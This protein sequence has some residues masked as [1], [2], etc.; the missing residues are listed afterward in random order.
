MRCAECGGEDFAANDVDGYSTCTRCGAIAEEVAWSADPQFIKQNGQSHA[1]GNFIPAAAGSSQ[2]PSHLR[3]VTVQEDSREQASARGKSEIYKLVD[4]LGVHPRNDVGKQA[5][6]LYKLAVLQNFTRGRS[7]TSV[8]CAALY[9]VCRQDSK[10][11][12]LIDFSDAAS[13]DIFTLG[14]VFTQLCRTLHLHQHPG[15]VKPIDPSLFIHRYAEELQVGERK[16]VVANTALR[17]VA[18]MKRDWLV[19]G[20]RPNGIC[21]AALWL[22]SNIHGVR[23]KKEEVVKVVHV[24]EQTIKKRVSEFEGTPSSTLTSAEFEERAQRR[25]EELERY[26]ASLEAQH[27]QQQHDDETVPGV[28]TMLKCRH[29]WSTSAQHFAHGMCMQCFRDF[30]L[31]HRGFEDGDD[32]PAL[33]SMQTRHKANEAELERL[34]QSLEHEEDI[35]EFAYTIEKFKQQSEGSSPVSESTEQAQQQQNQKQ[36][37]QHRVRQVETPLNNLVA[38]AQRQSPMCEEEREDLAERL[39]SGEKEKLQHTRVAD[40]SDELQR[41][42]GEHSSRCLPFI[43]DKASGMAYAEHFVDDAAERIPHVSR[44]MMRYLIN[45]G[46]FDSSALHLLARYSWLDVRNMAYTTG[47]D[48]GSANGGNEE[49]KSAQAAAEDN[50]DTRTQPVAMS[51]DAVEP[52]EADE[53]D[54]NEGEDLRLADDIDDNEIDKY[55]NSKEAKEW[56][57]RVWEYMNAKWIQEQED[58]RQAREREKAVGKKRQSTKR[59]RSEVVENASS[60]QE[61]TQKVLSQQQQRGGKNKS[62]K[63]N[64]ENIQWL[65]EAPSAAKGERATSSTSSGQ[66]NSTTNVGS[67]A[68]L[69]YSVAAETHHRLGAAVTNGGD[70]SASPVGAVASNRLSGLTRRRSAAGAGASGGAMSKKLQQQQRQQQR[71]QQRRQAMP[72]PAAAAAAAA[73][74]ATGER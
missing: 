11:F 30:E 20:R 63:V 25:H 6:R 3:A 71:L 67:N 24:C 31:E 34:K 49:N 69:G 15:I 74:A 28:E 21:G 23:K 70:A 54:D 43:L 57:E 22:A 35:Q 32:P 53:G 1:E 52:N 14:T 65:Y 39:N 73:A 29:A 27:S 42:L 10:P 61:A 51:D 41:L 48:I 33:K 5:E 72:D 26:M 9:L 47:V 2:L 44:E 38:E 58:K 40:A 45:A 62:R 56:K 59:K 64:Y 36:Q 46:C 17:V 7:S 18:S 55:I 66:P 4:H 19:S 8:A 68:T 16:N 12:M 60:A 37:P 13:T 50:D